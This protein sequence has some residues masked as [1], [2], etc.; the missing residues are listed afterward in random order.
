MS[1]AGV[2]RADMKYMTRFSKY[3]AGGPAKTI[4]CEVC[5]V[6][7][8]VYITGPHSKQKAKGFFRNRGW[9]VAGVHKEP[10]TICP[11][12]QDPSSTEEPSPR[13]SWKSRL[14]S[15]WRVRR[16]PA[17]EDCCFDCCGCNTRSAP[18][19]PGTGHVSCRCKE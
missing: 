1:L 8:W 11:K 18:A 9:K 7:E 2:S 16:N 19:I 3:G 4:V 5:D 13:K 6:W 15:W 17:Y 14:A 10:K 12:C